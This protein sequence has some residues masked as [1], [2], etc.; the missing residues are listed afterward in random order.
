[1]AKQK[2]FVYGTLRKGERANHKMGSEFIGPAV[3]LDKFKVW[4]TGFPMAVVSDDGHPLRG[5]IYEVSPETLRG[6]LDPYEGYPHFYTRALFEFVS[7]DEH[8][9]AWMYF[10]PTEQ[11]EGYSMPESYLQP[12]DDGTLNW[13]SN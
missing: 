8:H 3:S 13:S 6:T 10:I 4:G 12:A 5:E 11:A 9:I 1:M 2:V 7:G